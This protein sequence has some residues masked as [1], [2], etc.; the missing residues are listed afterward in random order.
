MAILKQK[1]SEHNRL[2]LVLMSATMQEEMF[3]HYFNNC[4]LISVEGRT[5]PVAIKYV[6]EALRFARSQS[7]GGLLRPDTSRNSNRSAFVD[8]FSGNFDVD[9]VADLVSAI[10]NAPVGHHDAPARVSEPRGNCILIF[11][12]GIGSIQA[13]SS[14]LNRKLKSQDQHKNISVRL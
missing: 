9:L 8:A 4:P 3:S 14:I 5:F 2:R 7:P 10:I 6:D 1:I 11:L 12:S 13:M